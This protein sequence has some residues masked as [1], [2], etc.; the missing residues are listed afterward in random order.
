M[1]DHQHPAP[2]DEDALVP[3][4]SWLRRVHPRRGGVAVPVKP[5]DPGEAGRLVDGAPRFVRA[6]LEG[7]SGDAVR[8]YLDG[9]PDPAGAAAVAGIVVKVEHRH[10]HKVKK[11]RTFVDAWA[12]EH[13]AVF[14][15]D[16]VVERCRT[17]LAADRRFHDGRRMSRALALPEQ[18]ALRRART[19][20]A[21]ADDTVYAA[22]AARLDAVE[23]PPDDAGPGA[24]ITVYLLPD[25]Q[26][27]VDE[28]LASRT[29]WELL[30]WAMLCSLGRPGQLDEVLPR[31]WRAS[32]DLDEIATLVDGTGAAVLPFLVR[33]AEE[34]RAGSADRRRAYDA[35]AVLPTD[36][37]FRALLDRR[38]DKH[39]RAALMDA[40]RRFPVRA[41]RLL[42]AADGR[43]AAAL[44]DGHVRATPALATAD[45]PDDVRAA[46]E[47]IAA[48]SAPPVPEA[49]PGDLPECMTSPPWKRPV[50]PAV[51]GLEPPE[52]RL[53]WP[54]GLR[55]RW[56]AADTSDIKRVPD[57][58][59]P[60]LI[61]GFGGRRFGWEEL[62]VL[63]FGPED[64]VRPVV[65]RWD[66]F[67]GFHTSG[68]WR[69]VVIARYGPDARTSAARSPEA[70]LP[71]LDAAVAVDMAGGLTGGSEAAR[72]WFDL[73]GT[74]AVPYLAPA[75]L[76]PAGKARGAAEHALRRLAARHG[77]DA[78]A[79]AC[80]GASDELRA[81]LTAHP[82]QTGLVK[83]PR[84]G[85]WVAETALPQVL[86][87]GGERALPAADVPRLLELLALPVRYGTDELRAAFEPASLAELGWSVFAHW[88]D[89]GRPSKE[90]WALAQLGGSGDD[91]AV[92]RLAPLIR[93]WPGEGGHRYA[94]TGL[95]VLADIGSDVALMH[96][97]SISQKVRFRGLKQR[98]QE[99]IR[100]VAETRGLSL[101]ELAD[102]LVPSF[103]LD[104]DGSMVLDYGPRRFTVGF[105]ERLAPFVTDD[106]GRL[107]RT[108]PKPGAKDDPDLGPAAHKAFTALKKDVRAVAA[109]QVRR[110]ERAM[111][112]GRRWTLEEFGT[113]LVRHP[114]VGHLA[115]R[116]VWLAETGDAVASFRVAEDGTF[117]DAG[118]E[119]FVPPES[120]RVGVAHPIHLGDA[121]T[122]WTDVFAD[123]EILQPFEQLA[124]PVRVLT[125][126]EGQS[127]RLE[128][129]EGLKVP[130]G[131][132]LGLEKRGWERAEPGEAGSQEYMSRRVAPDR[133]VVVDLAP[134]FTIGEPGAT[135]DVQTIEY[136]RLAGETMKYWP[137]RSSEYPF[138][139]LG[140]VTASE[141][142][143][144]LAVLRDA[145]L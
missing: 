143:A 34:R 18:Q 74:A 105:D 113:Y 14:A 38:D 116:L 134:G 106:S 86:Y 4:A 25:R 84:I 87:R 100:E 64:L 97:H 22:A 42:A 2:P 43:D 76:G 67:V 47:P 32:P 125:A 112:A 5:G 1:D 126:A 53:A 79:E 91:E 103:G 24:W 118:D 90:S 81:L 72:E 3:P 68:E 131:T 130:Y 31:L 142:L 99:K 9:E 129:F 6:L 123:Y 35:M 135:G 26:D 82:A 93:A 108:L 27:R 69:K 7:E 44:L 110:L 48:A 77:A 51:P 96:L 65:A 124:R 132:V 70:L 41:A 145:A 49:G 15:V 63:V 114:L 136:V 21:A 102:R 23:W 104:A 39:A 17:V 55:E 133:Y 52:P 80:P 45:L 111:A 138:G 141:I 117:A 121:L 57:P 78:V 12:A 144:D 37:A 107:R 75:A 10:E 33:A 122:A 28:L 88:N 40:M 85:G 29:P 56:L 54:G 115:R 137:S 119:T 46:V 58:D 66:G 89:L 20:L 60:E 139:E 83:P 30:E 98:A 62:N 59:W 36:D 128:R 16:A 109:D 101:D 95:D 19:L 13:G 11:F 61:A 127:A 94:V 92:R 73:H 50:K 8:R 140:P 71:F 120:A